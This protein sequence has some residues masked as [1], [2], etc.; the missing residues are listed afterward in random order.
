MDAP[1]PIGAPLRGVRVI[2]LT[3]FL[4]GP[5]A[6]VTLADQGADVIK[7]ERP[8]G[9]DPTRIIGSRRGGMTAMF[10]LANRGKRGV[11]IDLARPEGVAV[12]R[13]I[14]A[15]ADVVVE[16]YRAGVAERMGIGY[17]ALRAF[18]EQLIYV[19]IAGFG[20]HG[21]LVDKKVFDNL[22]QAVSGMAAQQSDLTGT[23]QLVKNM[24]GDKATA[25][26][27]AQAITAALF[28]RDR[29]AGGQHVEIAMLDSVVSFLWPDAGAA[30]TLLG[31]DV[32]RVK[33]GSANNLTRHRDGWST[34]A[35]VTDEEFLALCRAYER[36]D[37][38]ED[39]ALAT[40]Q[41]RLADPQRYRRAREELDEA[42]AGLTVAEALGRL[43]AGQVSAVEVVAVGDVPTHP[44]AI[45]NRTFATTRH[46]LAGD[47]IEPRP[48]ARFGG[49]LTA[50][51]APAPALGEHTDAV[52]LAVGYGADEIAR[53]HRTSVVFSTESTTDHEPATRGR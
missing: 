18:N 30:H 21:P 12:L 45:A 20:F 5:L 13:R 14:V 11:V 44:Q 6:T 50:P 51:G 34:A 1:P 29:G 10:H 40:M 52:L 4:S 36:P 8:P 3:T 2:D 16:N 17:D 38:A 42:A 46:P 41:A 53:L 15:D 33:S 48:P 37:L 28:A 19:S 24:V 32:V 43:D 25:L 26:I 23:P 7:I 9:G 47:M 39:P 22:I 49:E 27:A 31:D 35:A